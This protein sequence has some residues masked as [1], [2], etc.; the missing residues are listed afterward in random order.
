MSEIPEAESPYSGTESVN[1]TI[2]KRQK[3]IWGAVVVVVIVGGGWLT[4]SYLIDDKP[5]GKLDPA[6]EERI[7]ATAS[8]AGAPKGDAAR[9]LS[10]EV[11]TLN[12]DNRRLQQEKMEAE[13]RLAAAEAQAASNHNNAVRTI[14]ALEGEMARRNAQPAPVSATRPPVEMAPAPAPYSSA[15]DPF[16][17]AGA[18]G[19]Q[20]RPGQVGQAGP[21]ASPAPQRRSMGVVRASA[22]KLANDAAPGEDKVAA[23]SAGGDQFVSA[24]L[25]VYDSARFVPPNAYAP[26]IVQVGV[27][28]TTGVS[29]QA[30]PKPVM[31]RLTGPAT[32]V[33]S[34]GQYQKTDLTGCVVNGAAYAELSSEK[35]YI[36][37]QRITC[38]AGKGGFSVAAVEGYATFRGKAG[39]RGRVVSRE[40]GLTR[41]AMFA[42]TLQGLGSSLERYTSQNM[43][44]IGV[45]ANGALT[46]AAPLDAGQLGAGALGGGV[47]NAASVL[48]DYYVK[49]AE[50]YQPVIEM[51]TGIKV[52]LVFLKGFEIGKRR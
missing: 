19:Q 15:G 10:V 47:G 13:Q 49:R 4:W 8:L 38:P 6:Q 31:F 18:G 29:L 36:K 48:A 26:A 17:P 52:E 37:L 33:G 32:H 28:A 11:D 21:L 1:E 27:D 42:G 51:P 23:T 3:M 44:Q 14:S 39:V 45:G 35:V 30:D 50:Q 20:S 5:K 2:G 12:A 43:N 22:P 16:G 46:G 9:D 41:R 25:Q 7:V 24:G 34:N 40:G